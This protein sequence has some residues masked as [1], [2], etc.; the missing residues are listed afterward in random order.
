M[1][2]K[3]LLSDEVQEQIIEFIKNTYQCKISDVEK[4]FNVNRGVI[5]NNM[6]KNF[7][8]SILFQGQKDSTKEKLRKASTGK[9]QS[10]EATRKRLEATRKTLALRDPEVTKE[11]YRR[12]VQTKI[13]KFGSLE[14]YS[15]Y[16]IQKSR[17][18]KL[19]RYGDP[20]Y[21]NM[22]KNRETKLQN[23]GD[24]N[25]NN[26]EKI[27]ETQ[28]RLYGGFAFTDKAKYEKTML[29]RY[30]VTHNWSSKDPQLNGRKTMYE[31]AGSKQLHYQ[32]LL[33]KGRD[34][35]KKLYGNEFY[36]NSEQAQKTMLEKY[37]VPWYRMTEECQ[38][39]SHSSES[40]RK[41]TETKHKNNTFHHSK[42][43][44]E[45][46]TFLVEKFGSSDIFREYQDSRYSSV[47]G[48]MYKCDF[49]IKSK[50]L[51]IELNLFPT[52]N[53]HPFDR[54]NEEDLKE[55]DILLSNPTVWNKTVVDVWSVRDPEKLHCAVK[56]NLNY[57]CFYPE[58]DYYDIIQRI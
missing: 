50:D 32:K 7:L 18:T 58:D 49:Y 55:L 36:S 5:Y 54:N 56:N 42:P 51:F 48:T 17:A 45:F 9:K 14:K 6:D 27:K 21:N 57:M 19:Q 28:E 24:P 39:S 26:K 20:N 52:H 10:P 41:R 2:R 29:E 43:E 33:Q 8:N 25:Y 3:I 53:L 22:E 35:R 15:E 47:S 31:E 34:T 4:Q 30:G 37:G 11:I 46:Y 16:Q 38:R 23:H 13:D 40:E 12:G 44:E 1:S